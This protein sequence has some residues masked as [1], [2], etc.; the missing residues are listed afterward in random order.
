MLIDQETLEG[1]E[2]ERAQPSASFVGF[3]KKVAG[4][5][6]VGKEGLRQL[7]RLIPIPPLGNGNGAFYEPKGSPYAAAGNG[8]ESVALGDLDSDGDLDI[9]LAHNL[10]DDTTVLLGNG[11]ATFYVAPSSPYPAGDG[12]ISMAQGDLDRDEDLDVVVTNRNSVDTSVLLN[13][14]TCAAGLRRR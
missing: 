12:P 11:D 1:R 5:H 10:S 7:R 14:C 13:K 2:Q 9:V 6:N 8:P 3:L 4:E